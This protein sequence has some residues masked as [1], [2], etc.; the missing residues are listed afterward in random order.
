[1]SQFVFNTRLAVL[2]TTIEKLT[3]NYFSE[4]LPQFA[5]NTRLAVLKARNEKPTQ[6]DFSKVLTQFAFSTRLDVLNEK[7]TQLLFEGIVSN[8]F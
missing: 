2:I 6:S 5:F 1:L 7:L 3:Q 8:S 4:V